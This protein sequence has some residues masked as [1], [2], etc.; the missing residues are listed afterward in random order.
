MDSS[1]TFLFAGGCHVAGYPVGE[2]YAFPVL[3]REEL[4][5]CGIPVDVRQ[6]AYVRL[7]HRRKI[8]AACKEVRPDV[9][10]L[11]LG[12][13]E[14]NQRLSTRLRSLVGL[15]DSR[16]CHDGMPMAGIIRH[17]V[18]FYCR[19]AAKYLIDA[20]L[21]HRLVDLARLE[22]LLERLLSGLR[23]RD[24]PEIVVLSPMPCADPSMMYY[25][26]KALP[27]FERVARANGCR[28]LDILSVTPRSRRPRFGPEHFFSDAVHLAAEGQRAIAHAVSGFVRQELIQSG[29]SARF[30]APVEPLAS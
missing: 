4:N 23:G 28:F 20:C 19:A 6:L 30:R 17:P 25:R 12:H 16:E 21:G 11:Q 27:V 14:L 24:C 5:R 18:L 3:V 15:C 10:F 2:Q 1:L 26:R 29:P 9:L 8:A 22:S 13:P 7:P